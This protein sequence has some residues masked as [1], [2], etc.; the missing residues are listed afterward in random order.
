MFGCSG[1]YGY[2]VLLYC[3]HFH[4]LGQQIRVSKQ[5][6]VQGRQLYNQ[7]D[8]EPAVTDRGGGRLEIVKD[9]HHI[10]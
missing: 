6:L 1:F 8:R 9:L 10:F 3:L 2:R 7:S 5:L 4:T